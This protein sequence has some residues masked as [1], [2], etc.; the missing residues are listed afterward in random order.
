MSQPPSWTGPDEPFAADPNPGP[1]HLGQPY[2]VQPYPGQPYPGQPYPGQPGYQQPGY[3]QPGYQQPGY[4]QPEFPQFGGPAPGTFAAPVAPKKKSKVVPIV[5]TAVAVVLVL[6]VGAGVAIFITAKNKVDE[7]TAAAGQATAAPAG[8]PAETPSSKPEPEPARTPASKIRVVAPAKLNGRPKLTDPQFA[9]AADNL[10]EA[11]AEA[12]GATDSIGALYGDPAKRNIVIVA[13]VAAP[14]SA[15]DAELAGGLAGAG[16]GGLK[17]TGI[18]DVEPGPLGGVA[19][20]A[21]SNEAGTRMALCA[22]ADK[23]SV[24]W[25]IWYF[26]S[27]NQA[28]REFAKL[29]GQIEKTG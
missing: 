17:L 16:T 22:W 24:G 4:Q 13:A 15:P 8:G 3:Q 9:G 6:C 27:A 21:N 12:P 11:L 25:I 7:V 18:T 23:G 10:R 1:P 14:V 2:P 26:K 5:L 29:R 20:C 28:K 19:K